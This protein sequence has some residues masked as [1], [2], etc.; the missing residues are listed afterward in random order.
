M[1]RGVGQYRVPGCGEEGHGWWMRN[2]KK[3]DPKGDALFP[4]PPIFF[5]AIYCHIYYTLLMKPK[6]YRFIYSPWKEAYLVEVENA[7]MLADAIR[8][9]DRGVAEPEDYKLLVKHTISCEQDYT[10]ERPRQEYDSWTL[11]L[12]THYNRGI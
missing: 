3:R 7:D 1:R 4:Y 12:R 8:R 11:P 5:L 10:F 9:V 2:E 6:R